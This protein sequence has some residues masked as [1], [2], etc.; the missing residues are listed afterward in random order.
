ML[1]MLQ[2]IESLQYANNMFHF[3]TFATSTPENIFKDNVYHLM[4]INVN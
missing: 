1:L 3:L 2:L 4:A